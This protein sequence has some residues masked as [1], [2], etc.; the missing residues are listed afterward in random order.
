MIKIIKAKDKLFAA[1]LKVEGT[2]EPLAITVPSDGKPSNNPEDI[3][4]KGTDVQFL[5]ANN[6]LPNITHAEVIPG[7][8]NSVPGLSSAT[9]P[10]LQQIQHIRMVPQVY[11]YEAAPVRSFVPL[12]GQMQGGQSAIDGSIGKRFNCISC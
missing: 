8:Q 6:M 5:M 7:H 4:G 12:P 2:G 9:V 3:R 11:T 10:G 1:K